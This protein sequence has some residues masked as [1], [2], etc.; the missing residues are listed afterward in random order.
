[1]GSELRCVMT[2]RGCESCTPHI[3]PYKFNSLKLC[4]KEAQKRGYRLNNVLILNI[5]QKY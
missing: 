1:M 3:K 2:T 5:N 4:E